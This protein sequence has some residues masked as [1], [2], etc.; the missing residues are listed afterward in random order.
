MKHTFKNSL[1][2]LIPKHKNWNKLVIF[3][4]LAIM[5][6]LSVHTVFLYKQNNAPHDAELRFAE[7]SNKASIVGSVIPASCQSFPTS[8]I[9]H[10]PAGFYVGGTPYPADTSGYCPG[11]QPVA[12]VCGTASFTCTTGTLDWANVIM[13]PSTN[14][15]KCLGTT[16]NGGWSSGIPI[17]YTGA[18]SGTCTY[19]LPPVVNINFQ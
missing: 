16:V 6:P 17:V 1:K 18:N 12:G 8:G 13:G 11:T 2:K 15:W 5:V 14:T 3:S 10:Y 9:Q 4:V 19:V 7:V